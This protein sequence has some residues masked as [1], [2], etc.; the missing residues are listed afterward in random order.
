[1]NKTLSDKLATIRATGDTYRA[2]VADLANPSTGESLLPGESLADV[3]YEA[4]YSNAGGAVVQSRL[5]L[6]VKEASTS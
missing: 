2:A 1:M 6:V 3:S 4:S 5:R